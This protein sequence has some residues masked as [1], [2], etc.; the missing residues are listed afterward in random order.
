MS[1][2]A[3]KTSRDSGS[4]EAQGSLVIKTRVI[5]YHS[6]ERMSD[7][8]HCILL[9]EIGKK[10]VLITHPNLYLYRKTTSSIKTSAR[11]AAIISMF[12]RFLA[13][14]AKFKGKDIG[15]YHA[16]ADNIDIRQ[17]QIHRQLERLKNHSSRPSSATIFEDAKILLSFFHWLNQKGYLTNVDVQLK[18]WRANFKNSRMLSYLGSVSRQKI[19]AENIRV[20]DKESRQ[21]RSEFLITDV[22]IRQLLESYSDPVYQV[23]FNLALGTAMRPMDLVKFPFLG[24]AGNKHIMP[25]SEMDKGRKSVRYEVYKS[26]GNKDRTIVINMEDLKALEDNYTTPYYAER[27]QLYKERYGKPCPPSILFLN[28]KGE[29]VTAKKIASLTYEAKLK[30]METHPGFRPHICFY[31]ARHW[32]PTQHLINTFGERLLTENMD[33]LYL[34]TAEAIKNQMGHDDFETTYKYYIDMARVVMML[35]KGRTLDILT[36]SGQ[37]V[38]SFIALVGSPQLL[39]SQPAVPA[40]E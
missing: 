20:L 25:Y 10:K 15:E 22:E 17:W 16:L 21:R 35:H 5:T 4:A 29:P 27:K 37:T 28:K 33:V 18:T 6:I 39:T 26:K 14:R 31:Q 19:D 40:Y 32:W 3:K 36:D 23:L 30:A 7:V 8:T 1:T 2:I 38:S 12:Y 11:Y 24:N 13:T 9:A 34:A